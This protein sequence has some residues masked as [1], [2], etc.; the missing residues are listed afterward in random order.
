MLGYNEIKRLAK[1][2]S[3][4][5]TEL[6]ALSPKNDPFY[7]GTPAARR[8]AEWFAEIWQRAGYDRTGAHLRKV[9]YWTLSHS[10]EEFT[11]MPNRNPYQNTQ[12]CWGFLTQ[13][14]KMARYLGLVD[15]KM[16]QDNKN[17]A[18]IVEAIYSRYD[19]VYH[20]V[21]LPDLDGDLQVHLYGAGTSM[22]QPY[23]TEVWVEKSTMN[24]VLAPICQRFYTNLV[25]F[26]GEASITSCL[27]LVERVV[28][29]GRKPTRIFYV[30]DLD[31]AGNS[32]PVATARKI[33]YLLQ[34]YR[35]QVDLELTPIALNVQQVEE[36]NLPSI[37][38]KDTETRAGKFQ[39]VYDGGAVEL[40]AL[41]ALYPG[42]LGD[43]VREAL[44][45]Y[46]SE[47]A[48]AHAQEVARKRRQAV[49]DAV[50]QLKVDYPDEYEAAKEFIERIRDI[51]NNMDS[52][53]FIVDRFEAEVEKTDE[54]LFDS[55]RS[56]IAQIPFYKAH[57]GLE[58]V[59]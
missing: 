35:V 11:V 43:I 38:I 59:L 30:S 49:R 9:H 36:Y 1:E 6:L 58:T 44:E 20:E 29:A 10:E 48:E 2:V 51:E 45:K 16:V 34:K 17:P 26:E 54:A 46:Y 25:T 14:S 55:T 56:Y 33:E 52:V 28:A 22:A 37:P 27:K 18:P 42:A 32:M 24:S 53:D 13:A 7:A 47:D 57:K 15:I 8:D 31:P 4:P 41:E 40:D 39:N 23:H 3:I 12:L 5:V 21:D 50:E 19:Y